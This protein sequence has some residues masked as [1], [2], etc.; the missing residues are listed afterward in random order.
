MRRRRGREAWRQ[1]TSQD[2]DNRANAARRRPPGAAASSRA[3]TRSAFAPIPVCVLFVVAR[4]LGV[5]ANEPL[6]LLVG[7][8][9][10]GWATSWLIS[11]VFPEPNTFQVAVEMACIVLVIYT[12]GWGALLAIGF[13]FNVAGHLDDMGSRVG[14]PAILFS[15][16]GIALGELA[17]ALGLVKSMFPQP[18]GHG[19][20]VL[21]CVGVCF[22]IWM[23]AYTQRQKEIVETDLRRSEERLRGAGAARV[24]RDPRAERQERGRL[25]EPRARAAARL[26]PP[27]PHRSRDH[28]RRRARAGAAVL[29]DADGEAG[30]RR[31]DRDPAAPRRR[32]DPLVRSGRDEPA[33]RPRGVGPRLQPP[34]RERPA[35]RPGAARVPGVP[36][37]AHL[38]AE[39]VAVPRAARAGAVRRV[40]ERPRRRGAVPRRRPLQARERHARPRHR[41][42]PPREGRGAARVVPAPGR[43]GR[44]VRRRRVQHPARQPPRPERRDPR[45]RAHRGEPARAGDGGRARAVRVDEHRHRDLARGAGPRQRPP[46]PVR[47]RDVRRQGERPRVVG[48][49]R[50]ALG[51]ARDGAPGARERP[52]ARDRRGRARRALPARD[53]PRRWARRRD[54]GAD[55]LAAP[56]ARPDRPRPVRAVRGGVGAHRGH[57]PARAARGVPV[58]AAV[59]AARRRRGPDPADRRER[60]PLAPVVAPGRRRGR[61]HA[62]GRR[63]RSR[64]AVASR[65]SSPSAARS[66]TSSSR[67]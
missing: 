61:H 14:K 2:A 49:L 13:V 57:R 32:V 35:R 29:R 40:H 27:R 59:V 24:R 46:Q 67:R 3:C 47:P 44:A 26:R 53:G 9:A 31:V 30:R 66:P 51:A 33:R 52:V 37:R 38:P 4:Q 17:I 58:G 7:V 56:D 21:E 11:K 28:P 43:R 65:S 42:P 25:H 23:L 1:R 6:W 55:P 41:R 39:P 45:R 12:I 8:V 15:I 10:I 34:R 18:E 50:P 62:R 19:L 16:V 22:V 64:P 5:I 48:G 20:A 63:D 60:E 36:R 54:R